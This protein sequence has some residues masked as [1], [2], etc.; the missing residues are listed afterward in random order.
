MYIGGSPLQRQNCCVNAVTPYCAMP[1]QNA[2]ATAGVQRMAELIRTSKA[3]ANG[4]AVIYPLGEQPVAPRAAR[5]EGAS[6]GLQNSGSSRSSTGNN[7]QRQSG[8]GTT[9]DMQPASSSPALS[10]DSAPPLAQARRAEAA[11][12]LLQALLRG[13]AEQVELLAGLADNSALIQQL[14]LRPEGGTGAN[15]GPTLVVVVIA[16]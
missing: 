4:M 7:F 10:M 15:A 3:N 9:S 6:S 8:R 5:F 11:L 16:Q 14:R 2:V 1:P 13:R 12:V